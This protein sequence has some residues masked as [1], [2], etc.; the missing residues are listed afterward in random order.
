[1]TKIFY[2]VGDWMK[3]QDAQRAVQKTTSQHPGQPALS[4]PRGWT[5]Q[6]EEVPSSLNSTVTV[7]FASL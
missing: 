7:I 3:G 4:E 2:F 1:M 5:R 6:Y